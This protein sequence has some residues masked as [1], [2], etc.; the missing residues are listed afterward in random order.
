MSSSPSKSQIEA[1]RKY[2]A[3]DIADALLKLKVPGAGFLPDVYL[4]PRPSSSLLPQI[5]I[6][7]ASTVLFVPK[8]S[9][10]FSDYPK[11]NIPAGKHWVDLTVPET[12][13]IISQPEGQKNAVLGGIMALRAQVLGAKGIIVSGRVRDV[14]ELESTGLP[15]STHSFV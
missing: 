14:E 15:V 10:D 1:L 4:A 9:T 8:N 11:P 12:I 6:A 2:N 3:C 7:P 13:V 5:V